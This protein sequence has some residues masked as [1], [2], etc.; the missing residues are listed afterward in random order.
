MRRYPLSLTAIVL[1]AMILAG[2]SFTCHF[3]GDADEHDH[4]H[5]A[6]GDQSARA[7]ASK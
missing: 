3:H 2:G 1:T 5:H 4:H 6:M 7:F